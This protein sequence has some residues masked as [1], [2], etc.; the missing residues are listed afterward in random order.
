MLW[1]LM[2]PRQGELSNDTLTMKYGFYLTILLQLAVA[3]V[4]MLAQT[5]AFTYQGRLLDNGG[6]ANGSYDLQFTLADALANGNSIAGPLTNAAV[7]V[8]NGL[9]SVTLDFGGSAFDG[10]PRWLEIGVRTTGSMG[11]YTPLSPRQAITATPYATFAANLAP[12]A[13]VTLDGAG[14]T[15][16]NASAL[17]VGTVP[18]ARLRGITTNELDAHTWMLATQGTAGLSFTPQFGDPNLTNWA[19]LNTNVLG[20]LQGT[21]SSL[22]AGTNSLHAISNLIAGVY[23]NSGNLWVSGSSITEANGLYTLAEGTVFTVCTNTVVWT[24]ENHYGAFAPAYLDVDIWINHPLTITNASGAAVLSNAWFVSSGDANYYLPAYP[25]SAQLTNNGVADGVLNWASNTVVEPT[26][27]IAGWQVSGPLHLVGGSYVGDASGLSNMPPWMQAKLNDTLRVSEG[28]VFRQTF[29]APPLGI[30]TWPGFSGNI[31]DAIVRGLADSLYTNHLVELGWR[32]LQLDGGWQGGTNNSGRGTNGLLTCNTS[33]FPD[34]DGTLRYL[35]ERGLTLGLYHEMTK[36]NEGMRMAGHYAEDAAA[37][38]SWGVGYM[39]I[40]EGTHTIVGRFNEFAA[41][42]AAGD[43][44]GWTPYLMNG[45]WATNPAPDARFPM[46]MDAARLAYGDLYIGSNPTAAFNGLMANFRRG[47]QYLSAFD[48]QPG[49]WKDFD[50]LTLSRTT[51]G[52]GPRI[53]QTALSLWSIAPSAI[54]LDQ[55]KPEL[56]PLLTNRAFLA[57]HQDPLCS[58]GRQVA[59]NAACEVWM[60]PLVSGAR[61]VCVLNKTASPQTNT[62]TFSSLGLTP[63]PNCYAK[64]YSVWDNQTLCYTTNDFSVS[65]TN[66]YAS[67]LTVSPNRLAATVSALPTTNVPLPGATWT[68]RSDGTNLYWSSP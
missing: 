56:L 66:Y 8:T 18:L 6:P 19:R 33:R 46:V 64:V 68:L 32:L 35:R 20:S 57:V 7:G 67:L 1:L 49:K 14:I 30:C 28:A 45:S 37:L 51:G 36:G 65:L 2:T 16:L 15:N 10:S 27:H 31:N 40:D 13:A 50:F 26:Y 62:I 12:G 34:W 29:L 54:M 61:A 17:A 63:G 53:R 42:R 3:P 11:P 5:A 9:F 24:N 4:P 43:A 60:R 44:I 38:K 21:G 25:A 39:K 48:G 47:M 41:L 59:S 55:V 22:V 23:A 58:P 52:D